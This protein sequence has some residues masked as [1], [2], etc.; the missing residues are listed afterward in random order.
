MVGPDQAD[1]RFEEYRL[2]GARRAEHD[3]HFTGGQGQR[4]V[5]PD[6][7]AAEGLGQP[8]DDNLDAHLTSRS[9]ALPPRPARG[10]LLVIRARH[11][12]VTGDAPGTAPMLAQLAATSVPDLP[13]R[14]PLI[15]KLLAAV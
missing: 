13:T 7:V 2:A 10:G 5:A 4:D 6:H 9:G 12:P 14:Q 11:V 15:S 1:Q 8:L 3:A